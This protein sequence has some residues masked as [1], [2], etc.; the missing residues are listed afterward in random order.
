MTNTAKAIIRP[1]RPEVARTMSDDCDIPHVHPLRRVFSEVA[2]IVDALRIDGVR[3]HMG[4]DMPALDEVRAAALYRILANLASEAAKSMD[5]RGGDLHVHARRTER[6]LLV[7]VS[8]TC[9]RGQP[10]A[11]R[12]AI[13]RRLASDVGARIAPARSNREGRTIRVSVPLDA[14]AA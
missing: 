14:V 5:G 1:A 7:D 8:D 10:C 2:A 12:T 11:E 3:L 13:I 9:G 6:E 4:G